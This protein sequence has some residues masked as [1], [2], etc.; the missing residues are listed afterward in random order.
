MVTQGSAEHA[1]VVT[2]FLS[3]G[4]F[5]RLNPVGG[6]EL[7][8]RERAHARAREL[9]GDHGYEQAIARGAALSYEDLLVYLRRELDR[10]LVE[11]DG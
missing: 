3:S 4:R 2:G 9:L 5:V 8:R 6:P 1:A 11:A 10:L 7:E